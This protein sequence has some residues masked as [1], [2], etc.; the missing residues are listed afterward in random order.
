VSSF[1]FPAGSCSWQQKGKLVVAHLA[2][3]VSTMKL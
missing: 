1:Y 3:T 2:I